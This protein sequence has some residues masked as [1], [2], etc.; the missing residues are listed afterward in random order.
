[1]GGMQL[2]WVENISIYIAYRC[3]EVRCSCH[4]YNYTDLFWYKKGHYLLDQ[5]EQRHKAQDCKAVEGGWADLS[6][7]GRV[8]T[9]AVMYPA[10]YP[11]RVQAALES[12][13]QRGEHTASAFL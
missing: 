4:H 11:G 10:G 1:M 8:P 9:P 13:L 6:P 7:S 5:S 12:C 2:Y 3:D